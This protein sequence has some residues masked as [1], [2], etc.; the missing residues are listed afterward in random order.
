[1]KY[2]RSPKKHF[3]RKT[4]VLRRELEWCIPIVVKRSKKVMKLGI[5]D[6]FK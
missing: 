1:M 4:A 5:A 2:I 6:I 3:Q